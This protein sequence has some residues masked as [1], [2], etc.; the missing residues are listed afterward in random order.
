MWLEGCAWLQALATIQSMP[1]AAEAEPP[2]D[3][4][5]AQMRAVQA[6]LERL[7]QEARLPTDTYTCA[8]P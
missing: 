7:L 8:R 4:V 6:Q 1:K 2:Y 3:D 5:R